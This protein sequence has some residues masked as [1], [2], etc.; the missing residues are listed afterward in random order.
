MA[1]TTHKSLKQPMLSC[2]VCAQVAQMWKSANYH[3]C[4]ARVR[5]YLLPQLLELVHLPLPLLR[6][7]GE[8]IVADT[9]IANL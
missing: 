5:A 1:S 6:V 8:P 9:E 2:R 4:V 7:L 3:S